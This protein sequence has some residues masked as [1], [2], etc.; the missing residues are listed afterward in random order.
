[1]NDE[2]NFELLEKRLGVSRRDFMK[3]C[4]GVAAT[5]GLTTSDAMA[6]ANAV[7][8]PKARPPVIWLHGQECTGCTESLLRSEHPTIET[9]ILDLISLDYHETLAAAA[10]HQVE[11]AKQTSMKA[12]KGKYLLVIEGATPVKDGGI[13]CKIGGKTMLDHVKEAAEGAAAIVSIGSCASWGGIPSSGI[14]PTEAKGAPEILPDKTV[15]TIPGCPPNPYN[16]LSTVLHFV[17]FGK[18]PALDHLN[19]PKFA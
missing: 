10:G 9:L 16:F 14:N 15:V 1:M 7:A 13:Y 19:R 11:A 18:L 17:T 2:R 6:M 5:M 12:N 8:S 4:T 3:F